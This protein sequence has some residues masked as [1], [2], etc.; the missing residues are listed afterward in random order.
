MQTRPRTAP[1]TPSEAL[2]TKSTPRERTAPAEG[3]STL[4]G[5]VEPPEILYVPLD[6]APYGSWRITGAST[7]IYNSPLDARPNYRED[8]I[9]QSAQDQ[10]LRATAFET[11]AIEGLYE[12]RPGATLSIAA[13][14]PGWEGELSGAGLDATSRFDDQLKAYEYARTIAANPGWHYPVGENLIKKIHA[15]SCATQTTFASVD[16]LGHTVE[17]ELHHGVYKTGDNMVIDRFGRRKHYCPGADVAAEMGAAIAGYRELEASG[18]DAIH[19]SAYLHWALTHIHPFEDGNG[20]TARIVA[21]IPLMQRHGVPLIVFSDRKA[22]YLQAL[23]EADRGRARAMVEFTSERVVAANDL[24]SDLM[25]SLIADGKEDPFDLIDRI[26]S[27]QQQAHEPLETT[28]RRVTAIVIEAVS[29]QLGMLPSNVVVNHTPIEHWRRQWHT[30]GWSKFGISQVELSTRS[31]IPA[32]A[33]LVYEV[34]FPDSEL[35]P[36]SFEVK[37]DPSWTSNRQLPLEQCT[38]E[39]SNEGHARITNAARE[40]V[41][42]LAA[43]LARRVEHKARSLGIMPAEEPSTTD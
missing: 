39:V 29:E 12:S 36:L 19:L 37:V 14:E 28:A 25:K 33:T 43:E 13:E 3:P 1:A 18:T 5:M 40:A 16:S 35:S 20:R 17:R 6:V 34:T 4:N 41:R 10:L 24:L 31:P 2:S 26:V 11:G 9:V 15:L 23:D 8:K 38:P 7:A 32:S 21:S 27:A 22:R 30:M 42:E